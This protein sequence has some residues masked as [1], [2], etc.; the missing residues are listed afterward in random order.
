MKSDVTVTSASQI[1]SGY[2]ARNASG[3]L[4][5]GTATSMPSLT[6]QNVTFTLPSS[7]QD[8]WYTMT[9]TFTFPNKCLG[10]TTFSIDYPYRL[11]SLTLGGTK[12]NTVTAV[13][14]GADYYGWSFTVTAIGY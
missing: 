14:D 11:Y 10:I 2:K 7:K 9:K 13:V 4:L 8:R 12:N 5:T 1:V 6:T 3:T